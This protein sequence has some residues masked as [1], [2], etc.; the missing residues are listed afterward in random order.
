ML[1]YTNMPEDY[2]IVRSHFDTSCRNQEVHQLDAITARAA[3]RIKR[4]I[5]MALIADMDT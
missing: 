2:V 4:V 5:R 1:N 3:L